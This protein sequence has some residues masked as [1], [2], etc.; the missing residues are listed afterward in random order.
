MRG[1]LYNIPIQTNVQ[2]S[3]RKKD[4]KQL[5]TQQMVQNK[6]G[7][8]IYDKL[9]NIAPL[10]RCPFCG[11][12]IVSTLDHYLPKAKFPIFSVLTYNLI[13]SVSIPKNWTT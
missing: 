1:E 13:V 11:I 3:V 2:G 12:G 6:K 10:S 5:Y 8:K 7:R 4:M 9:M